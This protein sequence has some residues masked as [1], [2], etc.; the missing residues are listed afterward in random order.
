MVK[1]MSHKLEKI[2]GIL[3]DKNDMDVSDHYM[4]INVGEAPPK[5]YL[6]S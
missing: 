2:G 5:S 3:G 6:G 1:K 4:G